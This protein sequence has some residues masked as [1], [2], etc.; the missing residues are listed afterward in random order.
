MTN[1]QIFLRHRT[2]LLRRIRVRNFLASENQ[3]LS[4]NIRL[5]NEIEINNIFR[6]IIW[7]GLAAL[8]KNTTKII[9]FSQWEI[10]IEFLMQQLPSWKFNCC[11]FSTPYQSTAINC[12]TS[13]GRSIAR[14]LTQ[15]R[16]ALKRRKMQLTNEREFPRRKK[17]HGN[18]S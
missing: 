12:L 2:S 1:S 14:L 18:H 16:S 3:K 4:L 15:I 13:L 10:L 7:S 8:M 9:I 17:S 11:C 5:S 6:V